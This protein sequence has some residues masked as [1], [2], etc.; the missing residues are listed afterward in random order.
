MFSRRMQGGRDLSRLSVQNGA[1]PVTPFFLH[2]YVGRERHRGIKALDQKTLPA[3]DLL[4]GMWS[5][6]ISDT[7]MTN[8]FWRGEIL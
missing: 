2:Q 3:R 1:S 5:G 7:Q 8:E 4:A 6:A